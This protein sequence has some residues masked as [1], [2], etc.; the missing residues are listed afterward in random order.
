MRAAVPASGQRTSLSS[1]VRGDSEFLQGE[2]SKRTSY[3]AADGLACRAPAASPVVAYAIFCSIGE[4]GVRGTEHVAHVLVVLAM[5]VRVSHDK[6]D[7]ATRCLALEYATED[8]HLVGLVAC[9]GQL[10]L[11]WPAAVEFCLYKVHIDLYACRH[12]V[13]DA[14]Y[15]CPVAFSEGSDAEDVAETIAHTARSDEM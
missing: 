2:F 12:A 11:P 8:F 4:V 5:V 6:A 13:D 14:S 9:G 15:C 10:T 7:G 3:D 1:A